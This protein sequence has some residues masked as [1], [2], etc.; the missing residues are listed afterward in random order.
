MSQI[1]NYE[2]LKRLA[3]E[4]RA[5]YSVQT[6]TLN[7]IVVRKIYSTER[8]RIDSWKFPH[9]IRAAYM[10]DDSDPSVA[11]SNTLPREP[12]LFSL[13]HELK[14]HFMDRILIENGQIRCG[15]YNENQAIEIGAEVFAAEFIYPE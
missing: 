2:G 5:Q 13:V 11:I 15:D 3:R 4:K 8:I 12:K 6:G 7:L 1:P 14:H 10:C 9:T